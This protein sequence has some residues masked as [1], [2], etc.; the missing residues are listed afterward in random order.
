MAAPYT[1]IGD[2]AFPLKTWMMRPIPESADTQ[3]SEKVYNYRLR[4]A[5]R[6][7]ENAFGIV[8]ARWRV[9]KT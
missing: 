6:T 5:R 2:A 3:H 7:I 9:L 8:V 4:R 1:F